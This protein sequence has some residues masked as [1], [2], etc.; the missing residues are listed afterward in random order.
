MV[1]KSCLYIN[2]EIRNSNEE[3]QNKIKEEQAFLET[4]ENN[5]LIFLGSSQTT[6]LE[7]IKER[8]KLGKPTGF[9]K[10]V[11]EIK[12]TVQNLEGLNTKNLPQN[13]KDTPITLVYSDTVSEEGGNSPGVKTRQEKKYTVRPAAQLPKN[14]PAAQARRN[15]AYVIIPAGAHELAQE[16]ADKGIFSCSQAEHESIVAASAKQSKA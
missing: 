2:S 12:T 1:E 15:L 4:V 3:K 5:S 7:K 10:P 13:E 8:H 9:R 6:A 14:S 16:L 11:S